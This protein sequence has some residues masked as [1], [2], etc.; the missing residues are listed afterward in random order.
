[1]WRALRAA[2]VA[3]GLAAGVV[4]TQPAAAAD[5]PYQR[6]PDPT[7]QS[8]A[9]SRGTFATASVSVA[10]GN[11]FNGGMIYYP[12]DTSLGT[13]GAVAIVPLF[14][15]IERID[16]RPIRC[17]P[18][19]QRIADDLGQCAIASILRAVRLAA[20]ESALALEEGES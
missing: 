13:W 16:R 19:R 7:V 12:T 3:V 4:T 20:L 18:V 6:G 9:A 17:E 1:M 8:V 11:G 2:V 15:A 14:V 5:N 10:P